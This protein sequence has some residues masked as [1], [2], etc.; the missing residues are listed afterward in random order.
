MATAT[1]PDKKNGKAEPTW[2]DYLPSMV[3]VR[4]ML[5][6][7][8]AE[9]S[10]RE[11]AKRAGIHSTTVVQGLGRVD[12]DGMYDPEA[13]NQMETV[14]E[15]WLDRQGNRCRRATNYPS[16]LTLGYIRSSY[17]PARGAVYQAT[18]RG[19]KALEKARPYVTKALLA[20]KQVNTKPADPVTVR[21]KK[22]K[23]TTKAA[24]K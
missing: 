22:T 16:L 24:K 21:P 15:D 17:D 18:A 7:G 12:A 11:I 13:S 9:L 19:R 6:L 20:R 1:T 8:G 14:G 4:I 3:Q 23:K 5:A 10:R 2:R